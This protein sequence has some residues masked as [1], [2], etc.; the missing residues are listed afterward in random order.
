MFDFEPTP[1]A[2]EAHPIVKDRS[3]CTR[4]ART[5]GYIV[6]TPISRH[7][8]GQITRAQKEN[9]RDTPAVYVDSMDCGRIGS[10][11]FWRRCRL[12][13]QTP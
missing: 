2:P 10:T 13:I 12:G 6:T 5:E 3:L 4:A 1:P 8:F 7:W 9:A 11:G